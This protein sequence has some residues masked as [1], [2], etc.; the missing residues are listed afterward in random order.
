MDDPC[1]ED[2]NNNSESYESEGSENDSDSEEIENNEDWNLEYKNEVKF[3]N[4][5]IKKRIYI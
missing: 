2:L 4:E 3:W 1:P 5:L